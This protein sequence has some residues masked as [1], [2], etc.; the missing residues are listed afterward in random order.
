VSFAAMTL[1]VA[2]ERLFIFIVV[3]FFMTQSLNFWIYPHILEGGGV[4]FE[5]LPL[6]SYE[7]SPA[8]LSA[9]V[10]NISGAL[11]FL[12]VIFLQ[13]PLPY[14]LYRHNHSLTAYHWEITA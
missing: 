13:N 6:S 4:S 8:M 10:G 1:F 9:P 11:F 5:I 3:Y 2:F 12:T 7:L 14:L